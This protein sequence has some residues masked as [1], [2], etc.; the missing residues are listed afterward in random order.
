MAQVMLGNATEEDLACFAKISCNEFL[1]GGE[2]NLDE[3]E[4]ICRS[5]SVPVNGSYKRRKLLLFV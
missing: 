2:S 5:L 4:R 3:N 1:G